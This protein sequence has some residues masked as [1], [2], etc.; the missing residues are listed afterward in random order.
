VKLL[1]REVGKG[2]VHSGMGVGVDPAASNWPAINS[3]AL[4]PGS[5]TPPEN[6]PEEPP[7]PRGFSP[8]PQT[9]ASQQRSA[10]HNEVWKQAL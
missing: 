9:A 8:Q 7:S 10:S 2:D 3:C 4:A 6:K 1:K 5:L